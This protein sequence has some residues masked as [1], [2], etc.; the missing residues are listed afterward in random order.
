MD[1]CSAPFFGALD[2]LA[3][4]DRGC[5]ARLALGLLSTL[6][7]KRVMDAVERS[8]PFPEVE[9]A[10]DCALWR[11]VLRDRAPLAAGA[12]HILLQRP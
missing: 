4:D 7:I 9:I 2:A 5:R 3:V 11:Q 8:V 6:D 1:R 12:E 10:V